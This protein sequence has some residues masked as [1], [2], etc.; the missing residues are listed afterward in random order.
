MKA[1]TTSARLALRIGRG[2]TLREVADY[3][4]ASRIYCELRDRSGLGVSRMP[5]GR[6]YDAETLVASL[7]YNGRVWDAADRCVFD[8]YGVAR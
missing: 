4:E 7:S 3:A 8:P 1:L 6:I 5:G 2:R